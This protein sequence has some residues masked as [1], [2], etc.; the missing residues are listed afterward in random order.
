MSED[1]AAKFV[2]KA[3]EGNL[4]SGQKIS[5]SGERTLTGRNG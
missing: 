1:S 4:V 3:G 2:L 5:E